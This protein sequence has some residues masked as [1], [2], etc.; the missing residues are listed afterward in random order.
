MKRAYS[1]L[2][3][4]LYVKCHDERCIGKAITQHKRFSIINALCS[5]P[6]TPKTNRMHPQLMGSL[7]LAVILMLRPFFPELV[8]STDLLSFEH[9]SVLLFCFLCSRMMI[10]L[11]GKQLCNINHFQLSIHCDLDLCDSKMNRTHPR[12]IGSLCLKFHDDMV[13]GVK[14]KQLN[15]I[16][17]FQL[18]MHC[19][20][21][22]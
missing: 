5:R 4:S 17:H 16:N 12:L 7:V 20:L 18:S 6:L 3:E 13:I 9:P 8:M 19:D 11:E 2:M 1:Q 22:L 14:G 21:D 10:D 15:D